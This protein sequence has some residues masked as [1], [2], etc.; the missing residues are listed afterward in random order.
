MQAIADI[1]LSSGQ[2]LENVQISKNTQIPQNSSNSISFAEMLN[3]LKSESQTEKSSDTTEKSAKEQVK[4]VASDKKTE[5]SSKTEEN[6][7][8]SQ[9]ETDEK[10]SSVK[11]EENE[12]VQKTEKT[13]D[14]AVNDSESGHKK[15]L[16]K[17]NSGKQNVQELNENSN[18]QS[19]V[20]ENA[21]TEQ[22]SRSFNRISELTEKSKTDAADEK[23]LVVENST[24]ILEKPAETV[25]KAQIVAQANVKSAKKDANENEKFEDFNQLLKNDEAVGSREK[26]DSDS[27]ENLH[28]QKVSKNESEKKITVTDL[29]TKTESE[30]KVEKNNNS[31]FGLKNKTAEFTVNKD[32][33]SVTMEI[34]SQNAENNVLSLNNQTA[35]ADGSNYQAMLNNQLQANVPDIVKAGSIVLKDND[36]GTINLILHPDDLGNVKIHI[37][38]DGKTISGQITV[39]SKEALQVFKDNSETLREAF[40][41]QGFDVSGFDVAMNNGSQNKG[42]QSF[43]NLYDGNEF[44]ARQMYAG[45]G[46][47]VQTASDL[48]FMQENFEKFSEYSINIVA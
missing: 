2:P 35:G 38:M 34:G 29:R 27:F 23:A 48:D 9:T 22:V 42:N 14:F 15:K 11:S 26:T 3:S 13:K 30:E 40:I 44:V 7:P 33:A 25:Q 20:Q 10:I 16:V 36:Q 12:T 8:E 32:E 6:K 31:D 47:E 18:I 46:A 37:S 24:E 1:I 4:D 41:K 28:N 5:K 39:N 45:S 19:P 21:A 43:E 17:K